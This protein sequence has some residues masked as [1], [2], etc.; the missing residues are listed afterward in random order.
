MP[1]RQGGAPA[2]QRPPCGRFQIQQRRRGG[3]GDLGDRLRQ[4][5]IA[6]GVHR[7][8]HADIEKLGRAAGDLRGKVGGVFRGGL[9]LRIGQAAPAQ[10][11]TARRFQPCPL[12]FQPGRRDR[13]GDRGDVHGQVEA[14]GPGQ[15]R[16]EPPEPDFGRVVAHRQRRGF[17]FADRQAVAG[18]L[19]ASGGD[20]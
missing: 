4:F 16:L 15:H 8:V 3:G 5:G 1:E 6:A 19:D 2:V 18:E 20:S 9:G 11:G 14:L 13:A 7:Q 10:I 17:A 12:G